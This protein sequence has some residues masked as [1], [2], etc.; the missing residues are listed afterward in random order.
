MWNV[1]E[2]GK[3]HVGSWW[4]KLKEGDHWDPYAHMEV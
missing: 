3:M 4:G 2:I 1:W